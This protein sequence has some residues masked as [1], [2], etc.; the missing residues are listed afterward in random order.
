MTKPPKSKP[1]LQTEKPVRSRPRKPRDPQQPNLPLDPMPARVEPCLALLKAKPPK[2]DQWAY[3]I[4]WDGYRLA[5]HIEPSGVRIITRGGHD[6]T[7]R[8]PL[9]E[10]AAKSLGVSTAILD[11]EAVVLD[12]QGRSDFSALQRSLGGRGGKATSGNAIFMAFDLLYFDGHSLINTELST[13][14]HLLEGVVP[15]GDGAI[16]LSEEVDADGDAFFRAACEHGLEGIIAKDRNSTYRSG[17]L[18]DWVKVKCIQSNSFAIVG[19]EHS[20][21]ARAG[22]GAL[23]LAARR[24]GKLVY[25]GSVGT[26]FKEAATWKLREEMDKL[27]TK[28]PA[29][30]YAGRRKDIVW[31][32]PRLIA[33]I[34]YR[35]WTVDGKLRHASYKGLRDAADEAAIY[36]IA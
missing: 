19:Y 26:G 16:R 31:T 28:K 10:A 14:R 34:E 13:R 32:R 22:V 30:D 24:G 20:M 17:R 5:V 2:G 3:E 8:F 1:L 12:D 33:E 35:A 6:W 29:I 7:H 11:G 4:K 27:V 21:S 15:I 18:G 25:V 9:I 36:D 23:L